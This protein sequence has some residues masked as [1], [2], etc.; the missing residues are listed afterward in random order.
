M[1]D[2]S[3]ARGAAPLKA[4]FFASTPAADF[5][6][7]VSATFHM[8]PLECHSIAIESPVAYRVGAPQRAE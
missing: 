3:T 5:D 6:S 1:Q 8:V 4:R 2:A 7:A